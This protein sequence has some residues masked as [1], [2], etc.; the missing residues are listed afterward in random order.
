MQRKEARVRCSSE[1]A[2]LCD[3]SLEKQ[4]RLE[5]AGLDDQVK[6]LPER[7]IYYFMIHFLQVRQGL[8]VYS[9]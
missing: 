2:E 7:Y 4:Q 6:P 1:T 3:D 9:T 8:T 5:S